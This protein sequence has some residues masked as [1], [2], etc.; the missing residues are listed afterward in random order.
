MDTYDYST[1]I[2][3]VPYYL[4][5]IT[6]WIMQ[7]IDVLDRLQIQHFRIWRTYLLC[8]LLDTF[9]VFMS[10]V[11][12]ARWMHKRL[13]KAV[14]RDIGRPIITAT[15]IEIRQQVLFDLLND[16]ETFKAVLARQ[17]IPYAERGAIIALYHRFCTNNGE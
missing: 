10:F 17:E 16:Q 5:Q 4:I 8:R 14:L 1:L 9:A 11:I 7:E 13:A 3:I 15:T 6:T 2:F 12:F